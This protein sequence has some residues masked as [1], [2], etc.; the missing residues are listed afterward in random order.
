VDLIV[1]PLTAR[2]GSKGLYLVLFHPITAPPAAAGGGR[3]APTAQGRE[4]ER[5]RRGLT[6]SRRLLATLSDEHQA[7]RQE[8]QAANEEIASAN[9]ELQRANEELETSKEELQSAN[10]ELNTIN[11]ELRHSNAEQHQLSDDLQNLINSVSMALVL[12]DRDLRV[13][14]YSPVAERVLRLIPAD[15]GRRVNE[16]RWGI[17]NPDLE[18]TVLATLARG[19]VQSREVQDSEGHWYELRV[20]P[21]P[22]ADRKVEGAVMMLTNIDA[23]KRLQGQQNAA[24]AMAEAAVGVAA[25]PMALL[26]RELRVLG[27]SKTFQAHFPAEDGDHG[28][29]RWNR[30]ALRRAL[31]KARQ[32]GAADLMLDSGLGR[33]HMRVMK[34]Q[35]TD[36]D[37]L[38]LLCGE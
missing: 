18:Q 12:L 23:E 17:P 37:D 28:A 30:P 32:S 15:I 3:P 24:A 16:I 34:L 7:S 29:R 25:N 26:D 27:A 8:Y 6:A 19:D 14:R 20:H 21:F 5:L 13:R 31:G 9:E 36:E 11:E 4:L 10:E 1:T 38:Y 2:A 33:K 22:G 35:G